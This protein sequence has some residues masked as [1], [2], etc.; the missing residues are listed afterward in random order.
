[1]SILLFC[2]GRSFRVTMSTHWREEVA[3][4]KVYL[5]AFK[6]DLSLMDLLSLINCLN[7]LIF[8]IVGGYE[9]GDGKRMLLVAAQREIKCQL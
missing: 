4:K 5:D 3:E 8:F 1:M 2:V 7:W 9:A 6:K